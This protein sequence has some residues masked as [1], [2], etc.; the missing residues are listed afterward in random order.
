L[1]FVAACAA[2]PL[3]DAL[4]RSL[5]LS[6]AQRASWCVNDPRPV[7]LDAK[8]LLVDGSVRPSSGSHRFDIAELDLAASAGAVAAEGERIRFTPPADPFASINGNP[9]VTARVRKRP[10]I[11]STLALTPAYDCL[12]AFDVRPAGGN[13]PDVDLSLGT[14]ATPRGTLVIARARGGRGPEHVF[15]LAPN[16]PGIR[17]DARGGDGENGADGADGAAGADGGGGCP[18]QGGVNADRGGDGQSGGDGGRGGHVTIEVDATHPELAS[19]VRVLNAGGGGG[20]GGSG[21]RGGT[22]GNGGSGDGNCTGDTGASG[23]NGAPGSPGQRGRD[24]PSGG[25]PTVR[26]V[27]LPPR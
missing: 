27:A 1:A 9:V 16:G 14:I 13:A 8:I 23:S 22:G 3:D 18:P 12:A 11:L 21:G 15:L 2:K 4:L 25:P 26:R 20:D 24:G 19:L 7:D 5:Q 10:E 6:P 17:V